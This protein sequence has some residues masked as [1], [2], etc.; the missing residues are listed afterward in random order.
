MNAAAEATE[1]DALLFLHADTL[2][3]E[4][5]ARGARRTRGPGAAG[6]RVPLLA[7]RRRRAA[8]RRGGHAPA[9]PARVA[10]RRPG[11]VHAPR[12]AARSAAS[13]TPSWRT[14]S[15][16]AA[17]AGRDAC[18]RC[19]AAVTSERRWRGHGPGAGRRNWPPS[20]AGARRLGRELAEGGRATRSGRRTRR[21]RGST[22]TP[23]RRPDDR[24]ERVLARAMFA[25]SSSTGVG[26]ARHAVRVV[27]AEAE[28]RVRQLQL[29]R[30]D[31]LR[32]RGLAD[33]DRAG[34]A[35]PSDLGARVEARPER[36]RVG[37]PVASATSLAAAAAARHAATART[38]SRR[39][40]PA[41]GLARLVEE[42]ARRAVGQT[43]VREEEV[44]EDDR[45]AEGRPR[46]R[47]RRRQ[48][49]R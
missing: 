13:P 18:A 19:R 24:G 36:V 45:R 11:V 44:V 9:R 1:A 47:A 23:R 28:Q 20:C 25:S 39:S 6:R 8:A 15:S 5:P 12:H 48:W 30:E 46:G 26:S 2:P 43:V 49:W 42:R 33:G 29:P 16:R 7:R 31:R 21:T 27:D 4:L 3:P 38:A 37:R 10:L 14:T 22:S 40:V 17:H 35:Q 32:A 34:R 41:A